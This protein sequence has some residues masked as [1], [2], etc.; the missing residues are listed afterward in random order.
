M[1]I[2][3]SVISLIAILQAPILLIRFRK[4]WV[5][6]FKSGYYEPNHDPIRRP[7]AGLRHCYTRRSKV[8]QGLPDAS[9]CFL[10]DGGIPDC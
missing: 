5:A 2:A 7:A 9:E 1:I 10:S 3:E 6:A 8:R 4:R